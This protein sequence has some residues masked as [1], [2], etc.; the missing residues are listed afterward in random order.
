MKKEQLAKQILT[1]IKV[2][3]GDEF[4]RNFE[5]KAF[6]NQK[7]KNTTLINS[8]GSLMM[9]TGNL[10]RSIQ[11][12]INSDKI[13]FSSSLPYADIHNNGGEVT[14]TAKM[15]RYFWAMYYKTSGAVKSTKTGKTSN[16]KRNEKLRGEALQWKALALKKVGSKMK[17]E[18]RQFIGHHPEV[19]KLM[20][21]IIND[22]LQE[23]SNELK[24]IG[25]AP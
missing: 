19:D 21:Q 18:Q 6:F 3:L 13:T 1:D 25:K 11:S 15:K 10:R 20:K 22:N 14:V 16:T 7:W 24:K 23:I 2:K 9:R 8:R 12:N 4:D 17:I 5:R